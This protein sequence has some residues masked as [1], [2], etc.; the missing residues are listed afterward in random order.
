MELNFETVVWGLAVLMFVPALVATGGFLVA[1][2]LA[3]AILSTYY[4]GRYGLRIYEQQNVGRKADRF[5]LNSMVAGD[6]D[7]SWGRE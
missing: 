2:L 7:D 3:F 5:D 1:F 4:G 6:D